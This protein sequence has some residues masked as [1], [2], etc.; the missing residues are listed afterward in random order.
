MKVPAALSD[1]A[2]LASA[3]LERTC[4]EVGP[5]PVE[6]ALM[7]PLLLT[8]P[9]TAAR[10]RLSERTVRRLVDG[11]ELPA[12]EVAGRRRIHVTDLEDYAEALRRRRA[13]G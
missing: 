13:V 10:L 4:E 9:E 1:L 7:T 3:G 5:G 6:D 8:F 12:V 2:V 11:G